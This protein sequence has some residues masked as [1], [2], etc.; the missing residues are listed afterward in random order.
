M[1]QVIGKVSYNGDVEI[2]QGFQAE[3][4]SAAYLRCTS[5][6]ICLTPHQL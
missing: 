5:I 1:K 6:V 2:G 3:R 4:H